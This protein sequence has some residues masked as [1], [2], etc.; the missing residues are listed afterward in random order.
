MGSEKATE[1]HG[2]V[3]RNG[4]EKESKGDFAV[5]MLDFVLNFVDFVLKTMDYEG[6]EAEVG[7]Q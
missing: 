3:C 6:G 5:E 1:R 7:G 4:L 2:H